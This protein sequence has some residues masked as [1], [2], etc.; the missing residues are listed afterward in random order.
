MQAW[1]RAPPG[2]GRRG[3]GCA[4]RRGAGSG[5]PSGGCTRHG[6]GHAGA[7]P[8]SMPHARSGREPGCAS[9]RGA[10]AGLGARPRGTRVAGRGQRPTEWR[11]VPGTDAGTPE[12]CPTLCR[13]QEVGAP[14]C[15]SLRG[16][17]AGLG[18]RPAGARAAW[19]WVR[20]PEGRG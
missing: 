9:L 3:P 20:V 16:V 2:R 8:Y 17:D 10:D 19:A 1:V 4:S 7:V 13:T 18:A 11:G 14:G 15:A 5:Q 12:P 6:C